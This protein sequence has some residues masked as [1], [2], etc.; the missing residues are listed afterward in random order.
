ML[1]VSHTGCLNT[2]NATTIPAAAATHDEPKDT[3]PTISATKPTGLTA[4]VTAFLS[5]PTRNSVW[6]ECRKPFDV[7]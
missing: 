5:Y 2:I 4:H 7:Q 6:W 3:N 1:K